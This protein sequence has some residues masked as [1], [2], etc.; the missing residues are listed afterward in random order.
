MKNLK[1]LNVHYQNIKIPHLNSESLRELEN[2]EIEVSLTP[3]LLKKPIYS[4]NLHHLLLRMTNVKSISSYC[5]R[6]QPTIFL[7]R[8]P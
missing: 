8:Q 3:F 2:S 7:V 5:K 4:G 6:F 1:N